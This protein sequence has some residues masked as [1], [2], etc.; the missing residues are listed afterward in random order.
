MHISE[1]WL[2]E[3]V[4]PQQDFA[5]IGELLTN[6][7]C[8]VESQAGV[9]TDFSD[10]V[11]AEI[12]GI[13]KHPDADKLN[14]CTVNHGSGETL[15]IVCGAPNARTGLKAPLAM[16]GAQLPMPDGKPLKIKK[17][18]LRGVESFGMLCSASEL[19]MADKS[20]GLLELPADAPPGT[21]LREYLQL[22][23]QVLELSITPNRG[24]CLSVAGLA[25]EVGALTGAQVCAPTLEAQP[26]RHDE[27]LSIRLPAAEACPRYAGRIIRNINP[28]ARTP[29]WMK[30]KLRRQGL[31]SLSPIVDVTNYILLELGQPMHAFD[32]DQLQGGIQA[33]YAE[34]GEQ[35][36]LLDGQTIELRDGTL[37]IAD[38]AKAVALAGIMGGNPTAVTSE[39]R[40]VFLESAHF[41]PE[42]MAG[43]ARR[44][45][46][47]T[48]S[49]YRFERGVAADLPVRALER[50]T[51]LI[52]EICG[53]EAG[54]VVDECADASVL[55]PRRISLRRE[56]ITRILG[57]RI[58]DAAIVGI[59]ERLGCVVESQEQGWLV[60]TPLSRFD[61]GIEEDLVEEIARVQG[62][63][64]I[65]AILRPLQPIVTLPSEHSNTVAALRAPLLAR[66]YQEAVT[67]SFVDPELELTLN[68]A[69]ADILLA[70]PI[71][72]DLARMRT[73]LWSGL[74]PAVRH[75]LNRQQQRVRLF[76]T[77]PA[78]DRK[79]GEIIQYPR[80]AGAITGT[81]LPEQWGES[82][83]KVDF[84][85]AK[86]DV[87]AILE[88]ASTQSFHFLPVAH[89]ALHS[90]QC[91]QIVTQEQ[92]IG[93]VGALHPRIEAKLDLEQAVYL[94]ELD[95]HGL[96]ERRMP[97]YRSVSKFPAI[98]R[99][100]AL[101]VDKTVLSSS[102]DQAIRKVAPPQL[103][104]WN[105][106]DVY[107]GKGVEEHQKSV[108]LSLILQDFSR[109]LEDREVNQ[110]VE[111][112]MV[113]LTG[114]T[115]AVLR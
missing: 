103:I 91:A 49:S 17:G 53:G 89:P 56:R 41:R 52:L 55:E 76:E 9:A 114:E 96:Q 71:S 24:D 100:L 48:D 61:L 25:R 101:L 33:R 4:N 73:T 12:I 67:Y 95:L 97:E 102:L 26:A 10:V 86:G 2:R 65:P 45:G 38:D 1:Q 110:I 46:L 74:L 75:N 8:E 28:Q 94:F 78:F 81:A 109:T 99:D 105:I 11:I 104:R 82:A 60:Q 63:D 27:V 59:L 37:V 83:R 80:L 50:A 7:G 20:E 31:R 58:D 79:N 107:T 32:L 115:G 42:K 70:N 54:P 69:G 29:L 13:E 3:W 34:A 21:P 88:R 111:A 98:R 108:A 44:Y 43:Q 30:E 64:S 40:H 57:T 68:P 106:F 39:T 6:T 15:Q 5:A 22:D 77:G 113:S 92:S 18:K 90:G 87:E 66:G 93:W 112:V 23:D 19:G 14:V 47:Q 36:E 62:Y 72:A 85:D 35:L 84:F 51:Q 16:I